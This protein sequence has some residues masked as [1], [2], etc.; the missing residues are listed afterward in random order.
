MPNTDK[1]EA[2]QV[3]PG[4]LRERLMQLVGQPVVVYLMGV[5]AHLAVMPPHPGWPAEPYVA[6]PPWCPPSPGPGPCPPRPG[7]YPPAPEPAPCPGPMPM[8]GTAVVRGVLV[9]AGTD[10]LAVRVAADMCPGI[11]GPNAGARDVLIPYQ[12]VGMIVPGMLMA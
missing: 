6:A 8:M 11:V 4:T 7:P 12:A 3:V 10:F 9:F 2:L 1:V 5:H